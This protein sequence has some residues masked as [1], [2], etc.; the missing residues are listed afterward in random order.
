MAIVPIFA[1]KV[2]HGTLKADISYY[3]WLNTL[4]GCNVTVRVEKKK[5]QRSL[6]QNAWYW[7]VC[8]ELLADFCGYSPD[9]MHESLKEKFL[10]SERDKNGLVKIRSTAAL[11][12]DEFVDY[13]NRIVIWAAQQLSV[14]IPG[15][16]EVS[17]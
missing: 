5:K 15:P 9:E 12:T 7:G 8:V 13:T 6:S 3:K 17:L 2:E 16:G 1:A 4:E 10:G 14:F 11:S